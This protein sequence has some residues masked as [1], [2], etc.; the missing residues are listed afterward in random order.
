MATISQ[1][2]LAKY[3]QLAKQERQLKAERIKLRDQML[4]MLRKGIL[5]QPGQ[6]K[7]MLTEYEARPFTHAN[8]IEILG[9]E[10]FELLREQIDP[11]DRLIF[12]V[13]KS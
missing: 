8:L 11:V 5:T 3:Y 10:E 7:A 6:Y 12:R 9:E 1:K 4:K 2:M 13:M